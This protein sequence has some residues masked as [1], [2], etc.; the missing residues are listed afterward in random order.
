MTLTPSLPAC[1]PT[2]P[3]SWAKCSTG[4]HTAWP[5]SAGPRESLSR[6]PSNS[7]S[8]GHL[9]RGTGRDALHL[10]V[11][12]VA[13]VVERTD[14]DATPGKGGVFGGH[15][16]LLH[17][18]E[19]NFDRAVSDLPHDTHFVPIVVPICALGGG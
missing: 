5:T 4:T 16:R 7:V 10:H 8:C 17:V 15:H 11:V 14:A 1:V 12:P 2:G 18:V 13:G 6:L 19:V 3:S 9:F